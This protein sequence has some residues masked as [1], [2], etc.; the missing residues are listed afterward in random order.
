MSNPV[1][2][3]T[4]LLIDQPERDRCPDETAARQMRV[5]RDPRAADLG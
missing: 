2:L 4:F 3:T 5:R 1:A